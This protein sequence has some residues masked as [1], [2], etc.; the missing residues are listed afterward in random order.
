MR[1]YIGSDE[2]GTIIDNNDS[3]VMLTNVFKGVDVRTDAGIFCVY[4]VEGGIEIFHKGELVFSFY[5]DDRGVE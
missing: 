5:R 4:Q 2:P 1:I 3:N